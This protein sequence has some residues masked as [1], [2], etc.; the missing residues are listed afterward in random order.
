[1][2]CPRLNRFHSS[3]EPPSKFAVDAACHLRGIHALE[4]IVELHVMIVEQVLTDYTEVHGFSDPPA[5]LRIH[6][7]ISGNLRTGEAIYKVRGGI[8]GKTMEHLD[9]RPELRLVNGVC[10]L[11]VGDTCCV[12]AVP[13]GVK[14]HFQK[15]ISGTERPSISYLPTRK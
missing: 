4:W 12:L 3:L 7:G 15:G 5:Q 6:A 9:V 10:A 14:M 8:P 2:A 1:M 13:S 11:N